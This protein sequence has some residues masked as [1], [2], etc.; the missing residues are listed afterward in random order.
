M[1]DNLVP[2]PFD[3]DRQFDRFHDLDLPYL[4]DMQLT[5]ELNQLRTCLWGLPLD[6]WLRKRVLVLEDELRRRGRLK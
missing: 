5:D 2:D 6:H 1:N 3:T 4:D